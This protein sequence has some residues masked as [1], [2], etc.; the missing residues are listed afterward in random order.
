MRWTPAG[1]GQNRSRAQGS[2]KAKPR[3]GLELRVQARTRVGASGLLA[4]DSGPVPYQQKHDCH[5]RSAER[6]ARNHALNED[7]SGRRGGCRTDPG[8]GGEQALVPW[9]PSYDVDIAIAGVVGGSIGEGSVGSGAHRRNHLSRGEGDDLQGPVGGGL[10]QVSVR[11]I[12]GELIDVERGN[13]DL[14]NDLV[15]DWGDLVQGRGA[16]GL[17]RI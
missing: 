9:V 10:E 15:R 13:T 5:N 16:P 6:S 11:G 17:V 4:G 12:V 1:S 8:T 2:W 14:T 7:G 3:E